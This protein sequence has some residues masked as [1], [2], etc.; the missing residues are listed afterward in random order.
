M[1]AWQRKEGAAMTQTADEKYAVS[2]LPRWAELPDLALYM[3]QVLS[4]M[5]RYLENCPGAD[6]KG[7]T[8]SMV[9]NYVKQGV[10]PP[11]VKKRYGR[12][13]LATLVMLCLLKPILPIASIRRLLDAE[14][15]EQSLESCYDAFCA[16]YEQA[17]LAAAAQTDSGL[18]PADR[19]LRAAL[20]AQAGQALTL[21]LFTLLD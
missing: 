15:K 3:D 5:A 13:H 2:P 16:L 7:L 14:L 20:R 11:P 18:S 1:V 10:L 19:I 21:R 17:G 12:E 9:N 6:G 8:A 4:L